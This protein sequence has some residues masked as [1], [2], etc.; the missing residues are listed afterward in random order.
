MTIGINYVW[1]VCEV[2]GL[3]IKLQIWDTA[4]QQKYK[5]ITQN[6]Y[7]NSNGAI[8]SFSINSRDSFESVR[9]L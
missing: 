9:K 3:K 4:G 5:T 2:D 8:I 7:R 6:Y 1:N